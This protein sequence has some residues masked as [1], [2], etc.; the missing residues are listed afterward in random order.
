MLDNKLKGS[1]VS[2]P[3]DNSKSLQREMDQLRKDYE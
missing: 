1:N 2:T 3:K